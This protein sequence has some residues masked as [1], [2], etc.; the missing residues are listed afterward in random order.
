M[1]RAPLPLSRLQFAPATLDQAA[2]LHTS[3][4][5]MFRS[6]GLA[7]FRKPLDAVSNR[8]CRDNVDTT[9]HHY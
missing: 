8:V 5:L 9:G 7:G 1:D 3:L 2:A 6:T 4:A